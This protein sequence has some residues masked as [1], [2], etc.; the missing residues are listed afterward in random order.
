M[1]RF[2]SLPRHSGLESKWEPVLLCKKHKVTLRDPYV[3]LA[4]F[5]L[6]GE[7]GKQGNRWVQNL[8]HVVDLLVKR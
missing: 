2:E 8:E 5:L 7:T 3:C 4:G 1:A 6:G